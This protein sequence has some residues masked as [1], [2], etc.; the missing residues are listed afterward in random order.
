[1]S[2]V[3][4]VVNFTPAC[5]D[6]IDH[7]VRQGVYMNRQTVIRDGVRILLTARK[8]PPFNLPEPK[9]DSA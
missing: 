1:M 8:V 5:L 9:E 4:V 3:R 6:G 7:L 2:K